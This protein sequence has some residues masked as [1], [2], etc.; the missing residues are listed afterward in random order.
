MFSQANGNPRFKKHK[1]KQL[2]SRKATQNKKT[3]L[4]SVNIFYTTVF[5]TLFI[6]YAL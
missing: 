4:V 6:Y 5:S 3:F 2:R 1:R